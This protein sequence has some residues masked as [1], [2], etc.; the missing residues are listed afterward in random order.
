M[1]AG[2]RR[3]QAGRH[4]DRGGFRRARLGSALVAALVFRPSVS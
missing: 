2:S 1:S 3:R 4:P